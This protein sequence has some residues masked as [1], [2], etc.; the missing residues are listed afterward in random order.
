MKKFVTFYRKDRVT[1]TINQCCGSKATIS[2]DGRLSR[3]SIKGLARA[4]AEANLYDGFQLQ[5]G[6]CVRDMQPL[7]LW[8]HTV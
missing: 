2:V 4:Y 1:N 5:H 3:T 7:E 6:T 8:V